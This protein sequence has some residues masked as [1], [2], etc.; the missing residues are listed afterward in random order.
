MCIRDRKWTIPTMTSIVLLWLKHYSHYNKYWQSS[1]VCN[2]YHMC[3]MPIHVFLICAFTW[4]VESTP[5][6]PPTCENSNPLPSKP[7]VP[8]NITK[9]ITFPLTRLPW[10]CEAWGSFWVGHSGFRREFRREFRRG[11]ISE[12]CRGF[13]W[14]FFDDSVRI[15]PY[16]TTQ[17][18]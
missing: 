10:G 17:K 13:A 14:I 5:H 15:L 2:S 6:K 12:F 1:T 16:K 7:S 3:S 18:N 9:D 4:K 11:F 8:Q